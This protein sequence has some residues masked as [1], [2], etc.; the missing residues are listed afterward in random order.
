M[1]NQLNKEILEKVDEI[2]KYIEDTKDYQQYLLIKE[3]MRDDLEINRLLDEIRILQKLLANHYNENLDEKL[4]EKTKILHNIPLYRE[5]L[6]T[7]DEIN[8][9]F[10]I[11]E[12]ELNH[13]FEQKLN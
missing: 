10:N 5:Y 7:L 2:V 11:I 13:Y 3:R 9:T 8:N 6:N 12:N 4:Q 1:V